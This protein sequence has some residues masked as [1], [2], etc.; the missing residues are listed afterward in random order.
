MGAPNDEGCNE[1]RSQMVLVDGNF[2]PCKF[3][4]N[5]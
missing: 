4:V 3:P 5:V 1:A 2:E